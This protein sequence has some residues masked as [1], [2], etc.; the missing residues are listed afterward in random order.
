MLWPGGVFT[1]WCPECH[2]WWPNLLRI[3]ESRLLKDLGSWNVLSQVGE[4]PWGGCSSSTFSSHLQNTNS[5]G[6]SAVSPCLATRVYA[7]AVNMALWWAQYTPSWTR[8]ETVQSWDKEY[9]RTVKDLPSAASAGGPAGHYQVITPP[10]R[11]QRRATLGG[12]RSVLQ[13]WWKKAM[14]GSKLSPEMHWRLALTSCRG[15]RQAGAGT[16]NV[17]EI[18]RT[19]DRDTGWECP[20]NQNEVCKVSN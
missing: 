17:S 14:W 7:R 13:T 8:N 1:S 3:W 19:T 16:H 9:G 2:L 6:S 11:S 12:L 4:E 10:R 18:N 5:F 15:V 20:G